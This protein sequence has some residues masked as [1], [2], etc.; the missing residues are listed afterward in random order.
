MF[1]ITFC[2]VYITYGK[3]SNVSIKFI[4]PW[5]IKKEIINVTENILNYEKEYRI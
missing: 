4:F 5:V 2:F 3:Q 1:V